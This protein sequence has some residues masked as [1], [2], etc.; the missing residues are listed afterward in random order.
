MRDRDTIHGE[1]D[2]AQSDLE[3]SLSELKDAVRYEVDPTRN[4]EKVLELGRTK[5]RELLMH[6]WQELLALVRELRHT[7]EK[8]GLRAALRE[9][10]TMLVA[11]TRDLRATLTA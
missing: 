5:L 7:R 6:A 10:W 8:E 11:A 1:I 4:A 2:R 3:A 9:I